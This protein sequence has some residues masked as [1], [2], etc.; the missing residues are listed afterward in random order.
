MDIHSRRR[1]LDRAWLEYVATA[2]ITQNTRILCS[3]LTDSVL[4][5]FVIFFLAPLGICFAFLS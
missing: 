5:P 2:H 1:H 3:Y 4:I